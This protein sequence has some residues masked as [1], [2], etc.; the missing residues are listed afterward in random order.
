M[1]VYTVNR[2][3]FIHSFIARTLSLERFMLYSQRLPGL[4]HSGPSHK[5]SLT[6]HIRRCRSFTKSGHSVKALI[7]LCCECYECYKN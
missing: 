6:S 2:F 4:H 3:Y 1:T 5:R 7:S